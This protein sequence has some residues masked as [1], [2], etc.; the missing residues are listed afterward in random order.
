MKIQEKLK[1]V[2]FFEKIWTFILNI[3][4]NYNYQKKINNIPKDSLNYI[5][6]F[7]ICALPVITPLYLK[8]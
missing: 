1:F 6:S 4:K 8:K 5:L 2:I 7:D 3:L